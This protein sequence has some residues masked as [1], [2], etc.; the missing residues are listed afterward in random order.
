MDEI[1]V[2]PIQI[3]DEDVSE[4]QLPDAPAEG[5]DPIDW[6]AE[7]K[8]LHGLAK[9]RGTKLSKFKAQP[10]PEK[11]PVEVSPQDPKKGELD[12]GQKAYLNSLGFKDAEDHSYVQGIMKD[13]GKNLEDILSTP[14]VKAELTRL[15]EERATKAAAPAADGSRQG[16][17]ARDTVEYWLAKGELPPADQVELRRKVVDAKIAKEKNSSMF[18]SQPVVGQA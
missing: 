9:R 16:A 18:S 5:A 11:K 13:T 14:F 2:E 12:Y 4:V 3:D 7:A 15:G 6:E 1:N 10:K 8:R 17:P